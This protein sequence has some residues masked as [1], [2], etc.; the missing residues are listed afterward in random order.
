M[1]KM[2]VRKTDPLISN[3]TKKVALQIFWEYNW[4][5]PHHSTLNPPQ[6][7]NMRVETCRYVFSL[8][9]QILPIF[10]TTATFL[11]LWRTPH[12]RPHFPLRT[13]FLIH[14]RTFHEQ[15]NTYTQILEYK[16]TCSCIQAVLATPI[17]VWSPDAYG[18]GHR[19]YEVGFDRSTS[20]QV[21]MTSVLI[22]YM[23]WHCG[24]YGLSWRCAW[25]VAGSQL[26]HFL[27][28]T[29]G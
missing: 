23:C 17:F 3:A 13:G 11:Y 24:V 5:S 15:A 16:W 7:Y 22:R 26:H 18:M 20:I 9:R 1:L 10:S 29:K 19:A 12:H 8:Y 14:S 28:S 4:N 6:T 2:R 27:S 21:F 25:I